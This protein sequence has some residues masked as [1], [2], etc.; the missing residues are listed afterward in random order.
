MLTGVGLLLTRVGLKVIRTWAD[1][2]IVACLYDFANDFLQY[3]V[4]A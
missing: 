4:L 3:A 1:D 2:A